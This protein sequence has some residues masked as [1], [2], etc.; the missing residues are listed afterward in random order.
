MKPKF[1]VT[2]PGS[3]AKA[4][5]ERVEHIQEAIAA[6]SRKRQPSSKPK[7]SPQQVVYLRSNKQQALAEVIEKFENKTENHTVQD[8]LNLIII[9]NRVL[10][11]A[12]GLSWDQV[13]E[14]IE[15]ALYGDKHT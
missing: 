13:E 11:P 12:D 15:T 6:S 2:Y 1:T 8:Y 10:K 7:G 9:A 5:P 3:P 14:A 4:V